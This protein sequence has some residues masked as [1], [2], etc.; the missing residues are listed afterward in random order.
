ME[1]DIRIVPAREEYIPAAVDIAI[2][3]WTSI[4]EVFRREL[5][6]ELYEVWFNGWQKSKREDV[7]REMRSGR[8]FV[9]LMNGK[10]VSF[11]SWRP[12][13]A[14][15]GI[16]TGRIGTNA[17]APEARG[18]GI[19]SAMYEFLF[20][21]MRREGIEYASVLTGLDDGHAPA[22]RAYQ[23]AGF[24]AALPSVTYYKKL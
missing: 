12:V 22:R 6:D 4:R 21:E 16:M 7:E 17:V 15:D 5:G 18:H 19:G 24:K 20:N 3:A 14:A 11:G 13:E 1:A 9:T 2:T 23:K 10:V 8:G